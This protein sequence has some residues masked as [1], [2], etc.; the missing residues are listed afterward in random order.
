MYYGRK[1]A[2][3]TL[4]CK[5]NFAES[6]ALMQSLTGNGFTSVDF[7]SPADYYVINTCSVTENADRECR[8]IVRS[9]LRINPDAAIVIIGCYAQL[10][11]EEISRIP[12][13][14]LVLGAS[15]KH[16]LHEHLLKLETDSPPKIIA[17]ALNELNTFTPA[18]A[19]GERTRGFL[20]VQDGCDYHCS[21]CTIPLA[22]GRSRSASVE[23]TLRKALELEASGVQE[24]ILTGVNIGDFGIDPASGER[25][26]ETFFDLIRCL[27]RELKVPRLRISSIEPNLLS[28]DIIR[29]VAES[30]RF[31]PHFHIPLQSGNDRLLQHMRRKYRTALYRSRVE[32][33]RKFMPHAAIGADVIVGFPGEGEEEFRST[34]DF[35]ADLPVSY[36]HVFTYSERDNTRAIDMQGVVPQHVRKER[37]QILR[38]LSDKKRDAF[39][40]AHNGQI[41]K[42]LFEAEENQ[43]RM[44]GYTDNYI[45]VSTIYQEAMVNK[46]QA[47][48]LHARPGLPYLLT[49]PEMRLQSAL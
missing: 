2:L 9:A 5:L 12:G 13:V 15:D 32:A 25:T 41:R 16:L 48:K 17:G 21:F 7:S 44:F 18:A 28:E 36:L 31:M 37:N 8:S 45:K 10:K 19:H 33:I 20:K 30:E 11:P 46:V 40:L 4:G 24:I 27:D 47:V 39:N 6:A 29:F 38:R 22:R 3:H 49:E 14:K 1:V 42:V 23:V 34:A 35:L 43:G 26:S